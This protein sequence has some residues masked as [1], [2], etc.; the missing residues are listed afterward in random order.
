MFILE[1]GGGT[2]DA[3]LTLS[4]ICSYTIAAMSTKVLLE[5]VISKVAVDARG[6]VIDSVSARFIDRLKET[7]P[8]KP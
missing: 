7:P 3:I 1:V 5:Q 8:S 6:N 4:P 2:L